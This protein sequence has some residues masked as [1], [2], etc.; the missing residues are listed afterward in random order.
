[1]LF[2]ELWII[3]VRGGRGAATVDEEVHDERRYVERY[4]GRLQA[5]RVAADLRRFA[6]T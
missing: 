5:L 4:L 3:S 2:I 1:M 6:S